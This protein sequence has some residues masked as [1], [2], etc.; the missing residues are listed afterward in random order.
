MVP[1]AIV[2][3]ALTVL[4]AP[5]S[6]A[7]SHVRVVGRGSQISAGQEALA[8]PPSPA[9]DPPMPLPPRRLDRRRQHKWYSLPLPQP[10]LALPRFERHRSLHCSSGSK[11][12]THDTAT[13]ITFT[14]LFL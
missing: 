6:S 11:R 2:V 5:A 8:S 3:L 1:T 12:L 13:A 14:F 10:E 7:S 9:T 4:L